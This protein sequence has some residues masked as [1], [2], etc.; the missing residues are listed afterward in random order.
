MGGAPPNNDG[1]AF[2]VSDSF[3]KNTLEKGIYQL[4]RLK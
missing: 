1:F 4:N 2:L 3:T